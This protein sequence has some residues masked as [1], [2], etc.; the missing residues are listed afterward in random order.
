MHLK[1]THKI[2]LAQA[3]EIVKTIQMS[4]I[5]SS[6]AILVFCEYNYVFAGHAYN[7][8]PQ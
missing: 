7:L 2:K 3:L 4:I 5:L 8:Q 1:A 6:T